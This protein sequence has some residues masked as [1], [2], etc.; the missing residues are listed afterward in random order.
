MLCSHCVVQYRNSQTH[1]TLEVHFLACAMIAMIVY[2][3]LREQCPSLLFNF[4]Q[5]FSHSTNSRMSLN[6]FKLSTGLYTL[7]HEPMSFWEM[8]RIWSLLICVIIKTISVF[9][10]CPLQ[11]ENKNVSNCV[12]VVI[13]M[14][15]LFSSFC[16]GSTY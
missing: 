10:S 11:F 15:M 4:P 3:K 12:F 1:W 6:S 2:V 16:F 7:D 14:V 9:F 13:D 8:N 5:T